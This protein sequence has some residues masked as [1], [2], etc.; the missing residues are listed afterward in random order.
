[1]ERK[2]KSLSVNTL[3]SW[4]SFS[5]VNMNLSETNLCDK[6]NVA[7]PVS[8]LCQILHSWSHKTEAYGLNI[9]EGVV[10]RIWKG[11]YGQVN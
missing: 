5:L 9:W 7:G 3:K 6:R 11:V 10:T 2:G 8:N 1:M 4:D